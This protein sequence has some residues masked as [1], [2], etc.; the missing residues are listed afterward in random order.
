MIRALHNLGGDAHLSDLYD[1]VAK[2]CR[3]G[4]GRSLTTFYR[5]KVRQVVQ[6]SDAFVQ[7]RR[8]TG[9]WALSRRTNKR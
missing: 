8:G 9:Y 7:Y 3:S 1:E 6:K 2:V 4:S 5:E